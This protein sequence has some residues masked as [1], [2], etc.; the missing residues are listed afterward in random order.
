MVF[1]DVVIAFLRNGGCVVKDLLDG[2]KHY[3][4]EP[5]VGPVTAI[6]SV[7][8]PLQFA[9]VLFNFSAA[10]PHLTSSVSSFFSSTAPSE[11]QWAQALALAPSGMD[12]GPVALEIA[13]STLSADFAASR[14]TTKVMVC[15]LGIGSTFVLLTLLTI[16][17][18]YPVCINWILLVLEFALIYLLSVMADGVSKGRRAAADQRRLS[19]A[20]AAGSSPVAPS[21]VPLLIGHA[22]DTPTMPT[23]PWASPLPPND[24]FGL[25]ATAGYVKELAALEA[26]CAYK[27]KVW[28]KQKREAVAAELS[29]ASSTGYQ[30]A[31][32]DAV[33]LTLNAIAF[34]GYGAF[35]ITYFTSEAGCKAVIPMWPGHSSIQYY[36]NLAGDAAWTAEAAIMLVV[37]MLIESAAKS[38]LAAA[39]KAA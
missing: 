10:V 25:T 32:L 26:D 24:P 8:A 33:V 14:R 34:L 5:L 21:T 30:N 27:V 15:K 1:M 18:P 2:K 19:D 16:H 23:P 31:V 22:C 9:A 38:R 6:E 3:L 35:P 11:A 4:N 28:K 36:G 37:P 17:I 12:G 39:K 13:K 7:I 29:A 20:L